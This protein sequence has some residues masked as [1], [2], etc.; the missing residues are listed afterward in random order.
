[1]PG[2]GTNIGS[3]HADARSI[4]APE[5]SAAAAEALGAGLKTNISLTEL[6]IPG[7]LSAA[8][9]KADAVRTHLYPW[10]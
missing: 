9:A 7:N 3:I 5:S 1:M 4:P 8:A 10:P 2:E 6:L